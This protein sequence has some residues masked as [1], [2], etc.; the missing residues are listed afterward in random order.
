MSRIGYL[1]AGCFAV[2]VTT[3]TADEPKIGSKAASGK[4]AETRFWKTGI[5]DGESVLFVDN[6][7]GVAEASLVFAPS[8]IV[9]VK[10]SSLE[11]TYEPGKDYVWEKG[12]RTLTLPKGSRIVAR[13]PADLRRPPKSQKYQLTH[14]DGGDEIL[15]GA[16]HEYHD[17]QVVVAYK[18]AS[19]DLKFPEPF[20]RHTLPHTKT[21]LVNEKKLHLVIYGD[22]ISTGLNVSGLFDVAPRQPSYQQLTRDK[23]AEAFAAEVT[24]TELAV[25]GT[26]TDWGV[27]NIEKVIKAE[28]A[29]DLVVIAFGMN[30]SGGRPAADYQAKI[31]EMM[32]KVK[33]VH[34]ECEFILVATMLA[35]PDWVTLKHELFPQYRKALADLCGT[36]VALA[37]MTTIWQQLHTRKKDWDLTGNGVNHPNDFGHRIYASQILATIASGIG[38]RR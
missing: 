12:S 33:E 26:S 31:K 28:P 4:I 21:K 23:L 34:P 29:P 10:S 16:E 35:N 27:A 32:A 2:I 15:F 8:E 1:L 11:Q 24:L 19:N 20:S 14:R 5:V 36:G 22:S 6:G 13:K 37:D 7:S 25:G 3:L 30:D 38:Q 9:S 17:M 18:Y